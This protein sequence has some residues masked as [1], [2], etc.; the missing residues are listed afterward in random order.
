MKI[1]FA[2]LSDDG[3][4]V[5]H[6]GAHA[7]AAV[8]GSPPAILNHCRR[9][10]RDF[11]LYAASQGRLVVVVRFNVDPDNVSRAAG[12]PCP[13]RWLPLAAC[14]FSGIESANTATA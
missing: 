7:I 2:H 5:Y 14:D 3:A 9:S 13:D 6:D 12:L 4:R 1:R 8:V 10:F 11:A